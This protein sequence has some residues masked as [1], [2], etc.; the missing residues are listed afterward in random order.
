MLAA[1]DRTRSRMPTIHT[2][3]RTRSRR[4][5]KRTSFHVPV[6]ARLGTRGR[7]SAYAYDAAGVDAKGARSNVRVVTGSNTAWGTS[8]APDS[9]QARMAD[10]KP[11]V[12]EKG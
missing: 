12:C 3:R 7:V 4:R 8:V 1:V 10:F 6:S 2:G 11:A 9:T 5:M